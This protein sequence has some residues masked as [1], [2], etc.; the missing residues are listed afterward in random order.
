MLAQIYNVGAEDRMLPYF[1]W[2]L[3]RS[4][5]CARQEIMY[6]FIIYFKIADFYGSL[7]L[8]IVMR[9]CKYFLA[10]SWYDTDSFVKWRRA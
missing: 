10:K 4:V 5:I 2:G 8:W 3:L 6:L 9:L 1:K 7:D